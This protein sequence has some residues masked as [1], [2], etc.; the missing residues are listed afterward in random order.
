ML[1]PASHYCDSGN[2]ANTAGG[3]WFYGG[4]CVKGVAHLIGGE[5]SAGFTGGGKGAHR[6]S[7]GCRRCGVAPEL[8]E[9]VRRVGERH[10]DRAAARPRRKKRSTCLGHPFEAAMRLG[11]HRSP[12]TTAHS[13]ERS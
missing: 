5:L 7:G 3:C 10:S 11:M 6:L 1:M 13:I 2:P 12:R 9:V 4:C 8:E